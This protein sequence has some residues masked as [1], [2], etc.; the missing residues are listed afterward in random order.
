MPNLFI[1]KS[2]LILSFKFI[3]II[4]LSYIYIQI[5]YSNHSKIKSDKNTYIDLKNDLSKQLT[6]NLISI[7]QKNNSFKF[8]HKAASLCKNKTPFLMI[9]IKTKVNHFEERKIIRNTLASLDKFELIKKIFLIGIPNPADIKDVLQ[10]TKIVNEEIFKYNDIVQKGF[11]DAYFNNTLQ[12]LM[13]LEWIFYFCPK[14][15]S[16]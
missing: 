7:T 11:Y 13:G 2:F 1:C 15:L 6:N 10:T 12:T 5:S 14:V 4:Y 9:L 16:F 3:I 8:I